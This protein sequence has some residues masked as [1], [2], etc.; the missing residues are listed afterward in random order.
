MKRIHFSPGWVLSLKSHHYRLEQWIVVKGSAHVTFGDKDELVT[1]GQS[2]YLL[3]GIINCIKN[4][5]KL[6]RIIIE[7]QTGKILGKYD[8]LR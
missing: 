8:I 1:E 3:L 7:M 2:V 4:L 5:N 6:L